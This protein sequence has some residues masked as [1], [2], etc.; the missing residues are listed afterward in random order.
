MNDEEAKVY[1]LNDAMKMFRYCEGED[2]L[3][4]K[5]MIEEIRGL[6]TNN[7]MCSSG[8]IKLYDSKT[9]DLT[10]LFRLEEADN[11]ER[12]EELTDGDELVK[13]VDIE[14]RV[15]AGSEDYGGKNPL[16]RSMIIS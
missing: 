13:L 11:D 2:I 16:E 8:A 3:E 7:V 5:K 9:N 4:M 1:N 10:Q 14:D 12:K 6:V 15:L